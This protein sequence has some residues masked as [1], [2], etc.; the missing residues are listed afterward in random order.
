MTGGVSVCCGVG[1]TVGRGMKDMDL[2]QG[3]YSTRDYRKY[4]RCGSYILFIAQVLP[5]MEGVY[6]MFPLCRNGIRTR[7]GPSA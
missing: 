1:A 2:V 6:L 7:Q 3:K 5:W 4:S